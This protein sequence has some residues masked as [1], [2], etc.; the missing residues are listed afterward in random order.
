LFYTCVT[1]LQACEFVSMN[2]TV[3]SSQ[4]EEHMMACCSFSS[5]MYSVTT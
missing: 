2:V 5:W 3:C 1:Q 4:E